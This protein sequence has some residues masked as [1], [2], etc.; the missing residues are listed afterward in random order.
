MNDISAL[1]NPKVL[2]CFKQIDQPN[3]TKLHPLSPLF[4]F[5]LWYAI[6]LSFL[7]QLNIYKFIEFWLIN[8]P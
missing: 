5:S 2:K 6:S 4:Y 7:L 8:N 3:Q 1:D